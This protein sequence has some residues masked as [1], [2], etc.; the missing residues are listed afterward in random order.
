MVRRMGLRGSP[1]RLR[2]WG[3]LGSGSVPLVPMPPPPLPPAPPGRGPGA[4]RVS[5]FSLPSA[6]HTRSSPS[7]L[8]PA[9]PGSLCWGLQGTGTSPPCHAALPIPATPPKRAQPAPMP[10]SAPLSWKS[11]SAPSLASSAPSPSHRCAQDPRGLRIGPLISEQDYE[12]LEDCDP[13][14]SQDSPLHGEEQQPLLHVP[15]GLRGS[16]HHI[17]NLDTFFTN[18]YSYHQ[19]NGFTCILL[20]DIFQLGQFIFIVTFT[21]FLLRCVDYDVLFAN[22]PKNYTRPRLVQGKVAL[23]DAILPSA[24]CAER[25][26][27]SPLLVFLLVLAACYWLFQLLRSLRN[28]F[29]YWDIQVFYREALHIPPEELSSVPW[30]EVQSRLLEL[31]RSGGLCVQPR[32]LTELDVHHRILRYTNYQVALANKGLLPARCPLPWGGSAAFLSRGLALN[33]DLLLFRGPFS[34]F[35]GGWELP[36]AYKRSDQRGALAARWGRAALLL[37][38]VNLALSPV[39]LAWQVLHAFYSHTELLRREPGAF[40]ARR[41]SR[42]ARLQL[43]HFNELPHELRA[44]LAR[45]YRPAAAFLRAAEPPAPLRALLA[46]QLLFFSGALFAALLLLTVYDEDVL[47]VEHVF[48]TMTALGLAA[49]VARSFLPEEQGHGRPPQLLL[50]AALA[51]MHY[52]PEEPSAGGRDSEYRQMSQLLQYRAASL[53]EELLSPLLTPLFLLFWF[54][55]RALE[56]IDFFHHFTVDV[57]GVGD[58]CSFA[59]MDVKR[60]GH[61]QWLS[62]GQTEASTAQ[63]AENG[64]TELS[65]MRFSLAHPQWRPPGDSSKFLG[66]LRGRVQQDAAAWGATPAR[67]PPTPGVLSDCTSPL[68]PDAFLANLLVNPSLPPRDMSPTTTRPAAATASVLASISRIAQDPNCMSPGGTGAQKLV[69]LPELASAEMSLHA[70]YLHQLHQQQQHELWGEASASSPSRAW[71]SP[72]QPASP[73]EEKPSWS[74]D[75]S[76]P[77][78]SPRQ[79][80][81]KPRAPNL[82]PE[83]F[84]ETTDTQREP[85]QAPGTD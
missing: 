77:A 48:T 39:V 54:R 16:W 46:R 51:H 55:P 1:G 9:T 31:Q 79:Q 28:L 44:R 17:Q 57:A 62:E 66:H 63:R 19:R 69:Q 81:G 7:S 38:A 56:F 5:V 61:P 21:T 76:S 47:T 74:S 65:L 3:D 82:F 83:G 58:I 85:G 37:A 34:L 18:V 35:R 71:S 52:L 43:R 80:W 60:H 12:R 49:T 53:L 70:I 11:Q 64:K 36:D 30:A 59:L 29:S 23:S 15:E 25:I 2:R 10:S 13:E 42:L 45:A 50:Q 14:G 22:Q 78:S 8:F 24:Q 40:G 73:D 6:S 4:G 68:Q 72:S 32:P 41:W 67:S 26:H 20:E 84:Q 27:A 33:V 75:G